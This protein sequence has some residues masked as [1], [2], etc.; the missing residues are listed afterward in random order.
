[1][2]AWLQRSVRPPKEAV[3]KGLASVAPDAR[4]FEYEGRTF[5]VQ[6]RI[7]HAE[8]EGERRIIYNRLP[9]RRL[10]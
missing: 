7:H 9:A 6:K 1:M 4:G 2:R 10:W 5:L 3:L 8:A